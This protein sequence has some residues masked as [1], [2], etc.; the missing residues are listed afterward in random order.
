MLTPLKCI[1]KLCFFLQNEA[2]VLNIPGPGGGVFEQ[3]PGGTG[4]IFA[5]SHM[6]VY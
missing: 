3:T 2:D 6:S 1:N 4:N 5:S